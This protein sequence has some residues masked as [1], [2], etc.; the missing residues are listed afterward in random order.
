V[1][2]EICTLV[3]KNRGSLDAS[4]LCINAVLDDSTIVQVTKLRDRTIQYEGGTGNV[5]NIKY[6]I[7][8]DKPNLTADGYAQVDGQS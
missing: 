5:N 1:T 2:T 7:A 6:V 3:N 8:P 4:E